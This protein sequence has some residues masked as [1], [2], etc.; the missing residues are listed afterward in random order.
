GRGFEGELPPEK[1]TN[2]V[3]KIES[4][5]AFNAYLIKIINPKESFSHT[6]TN[7]LDIRAIIIY[8]KYKFGGKQKEHLKYLQSLNSL[9]MLIEKN[10]NN[11]S[12]ETYQL[13]LR[14]VDKL[15]INLNL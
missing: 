5:M 9:K 1:N 7:L 3:A 6:Y 14:R 10:K 13:L 12:P 4:E 11:L 15:G 8:L 2:L